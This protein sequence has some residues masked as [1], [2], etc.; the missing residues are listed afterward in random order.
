VP[1]LTCVPLLL[2]VP[3][4]NLKLEPADKVLVG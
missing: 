3:R 1:G 4:F 2:L